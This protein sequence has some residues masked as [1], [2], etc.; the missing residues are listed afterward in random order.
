MGLD[1][2]EDVAVLGPIGRV[3]AKDVYVEQAE[4]M[5][6]FYVKHRDDMEEL[7]R[8]GA[9][10]SFRLFV[11]H[12][13]QYL[14]LREMGR[15]ATA[16][17]QLEARTGEHF[18]SV[19][20]LDFANP[21]PFILKR[22]GTRLVTIGADPSR[23]IPTPDEATLQAVADTDLIFAPKCPFHR[24]RLEVMEIYKPALKGRVQVAITPCY[25]VLLKADSPFRRVLPAK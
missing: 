7:A 10:P 19:L 15:A 16:I 23:S 4:R 5:A 18:R 22:P 11:E 14:L 6:S 12:D 17:E 8:T 21:F 13:Y 20:T 24:A 25:D 1:S 2:I 3:S 9:L